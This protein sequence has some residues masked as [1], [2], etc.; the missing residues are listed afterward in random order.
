MWL[1]SKQK[2]SIAFIDFKKAFDNMNRK[3]LCELLRLVA[4]GEGESDAHCV[5][6]I[7]SLLEG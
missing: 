6:L 5:E 3:K 1:V 2:K 4:E 7:V